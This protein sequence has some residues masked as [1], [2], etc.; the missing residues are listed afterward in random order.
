MTD[1]RRAFTLD[2]GRSL[3]IGFR[4]V[5]T[6]NLMMITCSPIFVRMLV[7][8]LH[9][10]LVVSAHPAATPTYHRDNSVM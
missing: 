7:S 10:L 8:D 3:S 6:K 5:V 1:G 4:A 9:E 2:K